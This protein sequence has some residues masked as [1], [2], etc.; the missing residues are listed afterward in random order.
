[1]CMWPTEQT[2]QRLKQQ[3]RTLH[4]SDLG[5]LDVGHDCIGWCSRGTPNSRSVYVG[6][7]ESFACIW[8]PFPTTGSLHPALIG[9]F[10]RSLIVTCYAML[11]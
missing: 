10:V 4:G 11:G 8:D 2:T 9:G 5:P 1:M 7:S 6:V 3:S